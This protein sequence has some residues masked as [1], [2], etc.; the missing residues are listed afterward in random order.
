MASLLKTPQYGSDGR[1]ASLAA[2]TNTGYYNPTV[3]SFY[4]NPDQPDETN[5][6]DGYGVRAVGTAS[7]MTERQLAYRNALSTA[8]TATASAKTIASQSLSNNGS[9]LANIVVKKATDKEAATF[10]NSDIKSLIAIAEDLI[11]SGTK[12]GALQ[13][14]DKAYVNYILAYAAS[15]AA[16][17][18]EAAEL[19]YQPIQTAV[20]EGKTAKE[21][22]TTY[23]QY[24]P[25]NLSSAIDA[26]EATKAKAQKALTG[27]DGNGGLKALENEASVTWSQINTSLY[28][29]A[30]IDE[31]TVCGYKANEVMANVS[32]IVNKV[33]GGEGIKVEM[34]SGAGV[35]A[36]IADHCG[37]YKAP[38]VID[39]IEYNGVGATNVKAQMETKS[40]V[41]TAYLATAS[42]AVSGAGAPSSGNAADKPLTDMYG[43]VVDLAFRTNAAESKLLLQQEAVDR[44]YSDNANDGTMGHGSNMTFNITANGLTV[45]QLKDLMGAVRIVFFTKGDTTYNVVTA[46]KLSLPENMADILTAEGGYK[47]NIVLGSIDGKGGFT[48]KTGDE[49]NVLMPLTQNTAHQLSVLV[50]LDGNLVGNDDVAAQAATSMTGKLNLQF[51][52]SAN[53]VPMDYSQLHTP[54]ATGGENQG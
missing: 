2:N 36:D 42:T 31:I 16:G 6:Y 52:S 3:N 20:T 5:E 51:A 17:S 24:V 40:S 12:T 27:E 9:A 23:A 44:I 30:D 18:D 35:Y 38:I 37:N 43:Y 48:P 45:A 50:Y 22:A 11:G 10:D 32:D 14:V 26:L 19:A 54:S 4:P 53:L 8:N 28:L 7:G 46:G 34:A 47:A 41:S 25:S 39:K 29:L 33:L 13:A 15:A 21:I 49:A 1:V